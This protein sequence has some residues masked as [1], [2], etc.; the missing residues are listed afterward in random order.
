MAATLVAWA[1]AQVGM[2]MAAHLSVAET[3]PADFTEKPREVVL[4][5][6]SVFPESTFCILLFMK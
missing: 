3:G 2:D 1:V 6:S 4:Q 5:S